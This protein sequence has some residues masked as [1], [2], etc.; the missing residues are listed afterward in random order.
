MIT[1][2]FIN[3]TYKEGKATIKVALKNFRDEFKYHVE[4][5]KCVV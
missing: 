5:K 3:G 4:N 1:K 2:Q